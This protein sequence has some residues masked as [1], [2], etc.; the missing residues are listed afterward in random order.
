MMPRSQAD[1]GPVVLRN[2]K[3]T[4]N[5][6]NDIQS[7]GSNAAPLTPDQIIHHLR[8]SSPH[9]EVVCVAEFTK[10][11]S[12]Q[13]TDLLPALWQYIVANRNS[14]NKEVL[15]AV[16]SAIRKYISA[17]PMLQMG[18][19]ATLL[20][21]GSR[22]PL[23]IASEI[24]V[25]KMVYRCFESEPPAA[26]DPQPAL[27]S[28][29]WEVAQAYINPRVLLRDKY[30]TAASLAILAIVS[31]RSSLAEPALQAVRECPYGWFKDVVRDDLGELQRAWSGKHADAAS[32]LESKVRLVCDFN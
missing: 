4:D 14:N 26:N 28:N 1:S 19:L 9:P 3:R 15:V 16:G 17:L 18:E 24:E 25:A 21:S 32:W 31:M 8:T 2:A 22:S 30:A 12:S 27:A 11:T 29:L 6:Q 7:V 5:A 10:F 13:N 20:D 23:P